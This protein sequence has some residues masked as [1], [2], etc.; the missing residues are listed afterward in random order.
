MMEMK[1]KYEQYAESAEY[2]RKKIGGGADCAVILGTGL[3]GYADELQGA[4]HIPYADIPH[5]PRSTAPAHRGELVFFTRGSRRILAMNGRF[6][7]YE[8]YAMWQAAYPIAV[9]RLL[10][11]QKMIV[12]NAAGALTERY[13]PGD[14]VCLCDHIKLTGESPVR[15]ENVS[16]FGPRFFDMQSVYDPEM[17]SAAAACAEKL[18]IPLHTDGIYAYMTGP[19]YETPAEIRMLRMLGGTLVGMSTVPEVIEAAHCGIRLLC[20]S[21]VTNYA[22]GMTGQAVTEE[23]VIETGKLVSAR[24]TALFEALLGEKGV[25]TT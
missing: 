22:A 21:C 3:G 2:I 9:F 17:R 11:V 14:F 13:H 5:F 7:V 6:H 20:I 12:T 1:A 4:L 23:E 24:L 19:Q 15:G 16:Q 10:G 8:G 18:G 25:M